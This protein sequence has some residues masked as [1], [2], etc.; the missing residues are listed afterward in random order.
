MWGARETR[1]GRIVYK[2]KRHRVRASDVVR[3]AMT[4]E[5]RDDLEAGQLALALIFLELSIEK[6]NNVQT[7]GLNLGESFPLWFVHLE[8]LAR[9]KWATDFNARHPIEGTMIGIVIEA[10][11]AFAAISVIEDVKQEIGG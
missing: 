5:P 6:W 10:W 9:T 7:S 8:Q 2:R 4:V 11:R 1:T 3:W